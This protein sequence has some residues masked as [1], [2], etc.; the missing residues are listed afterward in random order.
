[1]GIPGTSYLIEKHIY[2]GDK[3]LVYTPNSLRSSTD[4]QRLLALRGSVKRHSAQL[5]PYYEL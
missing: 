4:S 1:M 3:V 2:F 5:F